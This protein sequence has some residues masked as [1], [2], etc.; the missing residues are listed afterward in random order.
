MDNLLQVATYEETYPLHSLTLGSRRRSKADAQLSH[1]LGRALQLH[2]RHVQ[3]WI[4]AASWEF[5]VNGNSSAARILLQRG[6]RFNSDSQILWKEYFRLE[7]LYCVKLQQR[8]RVL[9]SSI[10]E[11]DK[12]SSI[13]APEASGTSHVPFEVEGSFE[14]LLQGAVPKTVLKHCAAAIVPGSFPQFACEEL[15]PLLAPLEASVR[16][17]LQDHA[18]DLIEAASPSSLYSAAFRLRRIVCADQVRFDEVKAGQEFEKLVFSTTGFSSE[19]SIKFIAVWLAA[20]DLCSDDAVA[21]RI[22]K[23]CILRLQQATAACPSEEALWIQ[24]V[25]VLVKMNMHEAAAQAASDATKALPLSHSLWQIRFSVLS[26]S[27]ADSCDA[28]TELAATS[29]RSSQLTQLL[30]LQA[31]GR[32]SKH[33]GGKCTEET[34]SKLQSWALQFVAGSKDESFTACSAAILDAAIWSAAS[35]SSKPVDSI[36]G[37]ALHS[38]CMLFRKLM[39]V[40]QVNSAIF[41]VSHAKCQCLFLACICSAASSNCRR[42]G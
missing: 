1:V 22:A 21:A 20:L 25:Q 5:E 27:A 3:F 23:H 40:S 14:M 16:L 41:A 37:C 19:R 29:G 36:F 2:P 17:M 28:L 4:D 11:E 32:E 6:I 24:R 39:F 26:V 35:S 7:V 34:A 9:S 8:R 12:S 42:W 10:A 38:A 18:L 13:D 15:L 30:V 31:R 33:F